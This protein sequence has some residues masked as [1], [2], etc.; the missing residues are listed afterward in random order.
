MNT[1]K[2]KLLFGKGKIGNQKCGVSLF[3]RNLLHLNGNSLTPSSGCNGV[4]DSRPAL[5]LQT[6]ELD[7][8]LKHLVQTSH[9]RQCRTV[10]PERKGANKV[11]PTINTVF[12]LAAPFGMCC[13]GGSPR[14]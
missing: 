9:S 1:K 6:R 2:D 3:W 11:R 8:C 4:T 13:R 5:P 12:C 7:K 10:I 14:S